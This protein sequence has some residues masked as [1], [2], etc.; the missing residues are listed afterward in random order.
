M[1][2]RAVHLDIHSIS[3]P[4]RGWYAAAQMLALLLTVALLAGLAVRP[5]PTLHV[6]WDMVIPLLPAVFLINPIIWRN[7]CPL[8]TLNTATGQRIGTRRLKG[9]ALRASWAAGIA[10]LLLMV[11][12]RRFLFNESGPVLA[13]TIVAVAAIA[14]AAGLLFARRAGFCNAIC[15]VLPVEK[16]YGQYPLVRIGSARCAACSMCTPSGCLDMAGEKT[17]M[18]TLGP[19]RRS[20]R[21]LGT[22]FGLFSIGFPGFVVGYFTSE[23]GAFSTAPDVYLRILVWSAASV[24]VL[25]ALVITTRITAR[26]ALPLLG[27]LA[28]GLYYWFAAPALATAYGGGDAAGLLLRLAAGGLLAMW[29]VRAVGKLDGWTARRLDG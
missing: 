9:N 2:Y 26:V 11:P 4:S 14:L 17:L 12:A 16:L 21:W 5:A 19:K 10:L 1:A 25:G 20:I 3:A 29:V 23:N 28:F 8:A 6:L 18:Q 13:L 7:V 22:P 15:P 24:L 27:G